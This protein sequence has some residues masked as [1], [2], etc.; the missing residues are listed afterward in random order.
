M[1]RNA[2]LQ[3]YVFPSVT[4][5]WSSSNPAIATVT[6]GRV[7]ANRSRGRTTITAQVPGGPSASVSITVT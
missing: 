4:V 3:L 6:N 7:V 2:Q 5:I 1:R